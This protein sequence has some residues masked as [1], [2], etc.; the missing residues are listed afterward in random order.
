MYNQQH[1]E[2]NTQTNDILVKQHFPILFEY[3]FVFSFL[4]LIDSKIKIEFEN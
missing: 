1:F 3:Q 2:S 4:H